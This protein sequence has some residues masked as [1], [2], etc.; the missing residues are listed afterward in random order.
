MPVAHA[1]LDR[2]RDPCH[3]RD[4]FDGVLAD[5]G[6]AGKHHR[7]RAVE[8]RVRDVARLG[9]RRL[10]RVDHRLEHLRR[11]D[12]RLA[13]LEALEDDPLL[14]QRHRRHA[15]LDAE[16]A[17][18]DHDRVGLVEDVVEH[19]DGFG[20]LD[21]RDHVCRRAGLVEQPAQVADVGG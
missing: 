12:H 19:L 16:V 8:D 7:G 21:L 9:A 13:A 2:A 6:L 5:G 20:L 3:V 15:D 10:G 4:G 1:R 18:R 11:G 17:A 14:Q